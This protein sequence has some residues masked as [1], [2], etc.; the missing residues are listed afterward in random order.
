[1]SEE[2]TGQIVGAAFEDGT[3]AD[4]DLEDCECPEHGRTPTEPGTYI[5]IKLDDENASV[6][7]GPVKLTL[8]PLFKE[9]E[10]KVYPAL[11]A[12]EF[13]HGGAEH[14]GVIISSS[15]SGDYVYAY[16]HVP[17]QQFSTAAHAFLGELSEDPGNRAGYIRHLY[18]V[19]TRPAPDW[20]ISW[21]SKY[22]NHPD[23]FPITVV[24]L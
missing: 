20:Y 14:D 22:E 18:A 21:E 3:F 8:L 24:T 2:I 12:E 19:V 15:E 10:E 11:T 17:Y 9:P 6:Y 7:S 23:R 13:K 5:T 16:G 1:M 4:C